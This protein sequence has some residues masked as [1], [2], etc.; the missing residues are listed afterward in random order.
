MSQGGLPGV[1]F[2]T[3]ILYQATANAAGPAAEL[4][5]QLEAGQFILFVSDEILDEARDVLSRPKLRAK[6]P[7]VTDHTVQQTFDLLNRLH[8][9]VS[10]VPSLYPPSR[11]PDD[12]PYLNLAI[13]TDADYLVTRDK[14]LLDLMQPSTPHVAAFSCLRRSLGTA[15]LFSG[16]VSGLIVRLPDWAYP[17]VIDT[18][19]RAGSLRQLQRRLGRPGPPRPVPPDLRR[20]EGPDRGPQEG[21][22]GHR[23]VPGRWIDQADHSSRRCLLKIIEITVDIKGQSR[24]ETRASRAANAVMPA[25]SLSRLSVSAPGETDRRVLP[26]PGDRP[27]AQA[28]QLIALPSVTSHFRSFHQ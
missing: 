7:R 1:V 10:N 5:R 25:S 12:E 13:A 3:M 16:E 26:G 28:V 23:T 24:V 11:D 21:P 8:R 14:D 9:T 6:N 27:A 4:L 18:A 19:T 20:R 15:Q 17:V 2:D 22:P